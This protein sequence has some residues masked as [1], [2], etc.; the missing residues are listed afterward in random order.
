MRQEQTREAVSRAAMVSDVR[1]LRRSSARC[2]QKHRCLI[3]AAPAGIRD[4]LRACLPSR[5]LW[6]RRKGFARL[7]HRSTT[8]DAVLPGRFQTLEMPVS[9]EKVPSK[10]AASRSTQGPEVGI[11]FR[12][13]R[14]S[15]GLQSG[16]CAMAVRENRAKSSSRARTSGSITA[17]ILPLSLAQTDQ[18]AYQVELALLEGADHA[19]QVAAVLSPS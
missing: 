4:R 11:P 5:A 16:A 9:A 8:R 3:P 13:P 18:A 12:H 14:L 6:L 2:S 17:P 15:G 1:V 19:A 10:S 7:S